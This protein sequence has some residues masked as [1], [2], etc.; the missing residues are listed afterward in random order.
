MPS[1][2]TQCPANVVK[3]WIDL[4]LGRDRVF[5]ILDNSKPSVIENEREME[6]NITCPNPGTLLPLF[7]QDHLLNARRLANPLLFRNIT[8]STQKCNF[9]NISTG[10]DK[11]FF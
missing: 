11:Q 3:K 4:N 6:V 2:A 1:L 9:L 8:F 7:P 10:C 5:D